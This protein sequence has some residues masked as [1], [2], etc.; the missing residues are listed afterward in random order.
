MINSPESE[1]QNMANGAIMTLAL[2]NERL[3]IRWLAPECLKSRKFS[4]KSDL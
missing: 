3:P 2:D 4:Q 1:E